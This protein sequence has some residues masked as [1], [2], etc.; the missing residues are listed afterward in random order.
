MSQQ[1]NALTK[2]QNPNVTQ[3]DQELMVDMLSKF[4]DLAALMVKS[5]YCTKTD[6]QMLRKVYG[7]ISLRVNQISA[8]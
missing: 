8:F 3:T 6:A 2:A 7:S 4:K 1:N 5:K